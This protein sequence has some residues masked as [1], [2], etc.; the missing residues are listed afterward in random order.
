MDPRQ[1]VDFADED[2]AKEMRMHFMLL[3]KTK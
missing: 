2:K 1:I 3:C